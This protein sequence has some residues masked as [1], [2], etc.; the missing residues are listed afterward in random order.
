MLM[1]SL[2]LTRVINEYFYRSTGYDLLNKR[3]TTQFNWRIPIIV[4]VSFHTHLE[5][6]FNSIYT[7]HADHNNLIKIQNVRNSKTKNSVKELCV[8]GSKISSVSISR[9]ILY[10]RKLVRPFLM[11]C[12]IFKCSGAMLK[13]SFLFSF[14]DRNVHEIVA[15]L[16]SVFGT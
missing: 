5:F 14:L 6:K 8:N 9:S 15:T 7:I 10:T 3:G 13:I 16:K 4:L 11:T 1:N 2:I 12:A